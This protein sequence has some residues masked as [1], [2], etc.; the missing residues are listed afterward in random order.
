MAVL[1]ISLGLLDEVSPEGKTT[2]PY[3]AGNV[4]GG[5]DM[6]KDTL[7]TIVDIYNEQDE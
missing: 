5:S 6:I 7:F 2:W 4:G 1:L 3:G